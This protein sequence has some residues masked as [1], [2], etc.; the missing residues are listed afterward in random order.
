MLEI[1]L[2][3][4]EQGMYSMKINGTWFFVYIVESPSESDI[5]LNR[6]EGGLLQ[7]A[8]NLHGIPCVTRTT[9]STTTFRAAMQIGLVETMK[10]FPKLIPIIHISA[11]GSS[12]GIQLSNKEIV[13]WDSLR[14][15]LLPVNTAL[16]NCLLLCMSSCEGYS[17]CRMA[18]RLE[19]TQHPF[20][21]M[22]GHSG[23]PTWPDTAV[24]FT[25]LYHLIAKGANIKDAVEAMKRA[26]GD[27]GFLFTT[28]EESQKGFIDYCKRMD[29]EQLQERLRQQMPAG[30]LD[31]LS[32]RISS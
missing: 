17:A 28:A 31:P 16:G 26:S 23:K 10:V 2:G 30:A 20:I 8:I 12:E 32:K 21:S 13:S 19:S 15:L 22:I 24:A 9:I 25:T 1:V 18:M 4:H 14:E 27:N 6:S 11:H 3:R 29:A 5:Y 7:Q